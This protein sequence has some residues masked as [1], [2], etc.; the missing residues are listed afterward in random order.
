MRKYVFNL[1]DITLDKIV[2]TVGYRESKNKT[3]NKVIE[4]AKLNE[5][6]REKINNL[7]QTR[8]DTNRPVQSQKLARSLKL[9][10]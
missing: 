3:R 4:S 9:W 2:T 7:Y 6:S 1:H 10:I 8:S 5:L